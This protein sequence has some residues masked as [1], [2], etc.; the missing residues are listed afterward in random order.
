M[1]VAAAVLPHP[2]LL[3]PELASGASP[4]LGHVRSACLDALKPLMAVDC[5]RV[6]VVGTGTER[7][8]FAAGARGSTAGFGV[9]VEVGLPGTPPDAAT[10][11]AGS[12]PLSLTVGAWLMSQAGEW[13]STAPTVAGEAIAV[14]A[15]PSDAAQLG[16][17]LATSADR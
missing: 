1:L 10:A 5:D 16:R 14:D 8:T 7:I 15:R 12:M 11:G 6:Y 3:I 17:D 4:E 2:P 13:S 9:R